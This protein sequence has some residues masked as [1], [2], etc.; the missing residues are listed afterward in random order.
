YRRT[1]STA[2]DVLLEQDPAAAT[3]LGD[4]RYDD[5]LPDLSAGGVA[6]SLTE[7]GTAVGALDDLDDTVLE[8]QDLV[9]LELL[10]GRLTAMQWSLTDLAEH[11]WNPLA[12]LPGEAVHSLVSRATGDPHERAGALAARLGGVPRLL[13][14]ARATLRQMPRVHVETAITQA[15]G[16]RALLGAP[17]DELLARAPGARAE[18]DA[19]REVAAVALEEHAG[20]LHDQ[21]PLAERDP[22]LRP[23]A[24]AARL[25]SALDTE[26][27]PDALLTRAESDLMALE[28]QLAELCARLGPALGVDA[29]APDRVRAVLDAV[30]AGAPTTDDDVLDQCVAHLSRL[31]ELVR[32]HDLVTVPESLVA[33]T[34]VI[35]MPEVNRGVAVA[36]CDAPG[37]LEPG[38]PHPTFFAVAPTPQGWSAEQVASFYR[39]YNGHMLRDLTAHE[40]MPGHVLQLAHAREFVGSTPVRAALASGVLIEGWAVYAEQLVADA[41]EQDAPD[42]LATMCLR[43]QQLKMRLRCT[44]NAILDVRVHTRGM[45]QDEAMTLMTRRGHQEVG[46]AAGKWRR[47]LLTSSQL[48]TY[49]VGHDEVS[50]I[51]ADLAAARSAISRRGVHDELLSHGS[52]SPRLL[53]GLLDLPEAPAR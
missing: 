22:R 39:E 36:Y 33:S 44:I 2:L 4:H 15:R 25:W 6:A 47:A 45:T 31:T 19:A 26:T 27:G 51:A 46:E 53:R 42:D 18:V 7:I 50:S 11:T 48:S 14:T 37:A 17:V 21:L 41:L 16:A 29:P 12:H 32:A 23:D 9:D 8:P 1:A 28:E 30:A 35:V 3:A 40:A 38:G 20:W 24:F 5:R 52:P 49:Y 34:E 13:E 43:L 10:R